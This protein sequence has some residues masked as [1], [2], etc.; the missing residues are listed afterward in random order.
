[1]IDDNDEI[2][3]EVIP[4][5][6]SFYFHHSCTEHVSFST[7]ASIFQIPVYLSKSL[8]D[9]LFVLQYPNVKCKLNLDAAQVVN[10]RVKPTNQEFKLDLALDTASR[11][12]D[13]FKGEQF[14]IAADG[15]VSLDPVLILTAVN[16]H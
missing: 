4:S 11:H 13:A 3:E 9:N 15:K 5:F 16:F 7:T 14:A 8:A 12:Y 1:M 2:L 10:S 6:V